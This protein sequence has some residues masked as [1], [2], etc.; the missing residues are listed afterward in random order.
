MDHSVKTLSSRPNIRLQWMLQRRRFESDE[1]E[2]LYQKYIFKLQQSSITSVL[3]LSIVLSGALSIISLVFTGTATVQNI[4]YAVQCVLFFMLLTYINTKYM[5]DSQLLAICYIILVLGV[6]FS[7]ISFPV[8]YTIA[9]DPDNEWLRAG[10]EGVWEIIFVVFLVYAILP[11]KTY[12]AV[13]FGILLPVC[14]S[15][16]VVLC[17]KD[18][19]TLPLW[20][21]VGNFVTH[22]ILFFL[23]KCFMAC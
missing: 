6:L 7:A 12:F 22:R 5:K 3:L 16:V 4:Y 9:D 1:L 15:V 21:Q 8:N 23:Y 13:V 2:E 18:V 14:H 10:P 17:V 20:L 11:L 19:F